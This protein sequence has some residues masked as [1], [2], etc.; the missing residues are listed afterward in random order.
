MIL[1]CQKQVSKAESV[2]VVN[3]FC[4]LQAILLKLVSKFTGQVMPLRLKTSIL[5]FKLNLQDFNRRSLIESITLNW[6]AK[7]Y[8]DLVELWLILSWNDFL[9]R[10]RTRAQIPLNFCQHNNHEDLHY[11]SDSIKLLL[12]QKIYCTYLHYKKESFLYDYNH[13]VLLWCESL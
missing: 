13:C 7:L 6:D 5:L 1:T 4:V 12:T 11:I 2:R 10:I 3:L 8:L 9:S